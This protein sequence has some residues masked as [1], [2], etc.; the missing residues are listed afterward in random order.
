MGGLI[1]IFLR[2]MSADAAT[3][4]F[5]VLV[6]AVFLFACHQARKG[7]AQAFV[8]NAPALMTSLGILG[9]FVGIVIGLLSFDVSTIDTSISTLLEGMKTAFIT[10]LV[11]MTFSIAFKLLD[12]WKFSV[13]RDAAHAPQ[14]VTPAHILGALEKQTQAIG[15]LAT[16]LSGNEE[17]S[18]VGQM[19]LFRSDVSD[20]TRQAALAREKFEQKLLVDL[21]GVSTLKDFHAQQL[22][23][24]GGLH[25]LITQTANRQDE[26]RQVL[27]DQLLATTSE[28]STKLD[29]AS[30]RRQNQ[31]GEL[32]ASLQ[33]G[34][35][36]IT[37]IADRQDEARKQFE[38]QL[39][40]E[41][42]E[43][44][45]LMSRS[46]TEAVIEALRQV[47]VEF[48]TNLTE[49]FGENFKAL[50]ASVQKL[51]EWQDR[52]A[53]QV[54]QMGQQFQRSVD[55]VDTTR[56]ALVKIG[57]ECS[58]IPASMDELRAVIVIN[59][60]QIQELARH[61]E[62]FVQMRDKAVEA[63]PQ[64]RE[65]IGFV[66]EQL[67]AAAVDM[68]EVLAEKSEL[69][70]S[71]VN[72][73]NRAV[74]EMANEVS[75]STDKLREEF[76]G[77]VNELTSAA[78]EMVRSLEVAANEVH[79]QVRQS[80]EGMVDAIQRDT[81]RMLSG[82]EKQV[83]EAVGKTGEAVNTQLSAIDQGLAQELERVFNRFGTS[84]ARISDA[85]TR[86]YENVVKR[87]AEMARKVS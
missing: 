83:A 27:K 37:E 21:E 39:F 30:E 67:G 74:I 13:A 26:A 64:I 33:V 85:Y 60:H 71:H 4:V 12:D 50:D 53:G 15:G 66:T 86:D 76:T 58:R 49:Q 51:V 44:A 24:M 70:A 7:K 20:Q 78:R 43:F 23:L 41:M 73:T 56:E 29:Q 87:I 81:G 75:N 2:G 19:K 72:S 1:E 35:E 31:H 79:E 82:V 45:D 36:L 40:A 57:E 84:L 38:I 65:Q 5:C 62:A 17:G 22:S 54:D 8:R 18:I 77:S 11:G 80:T 68:S 3:E 59:Q 9:T 61:L 69:F 6:V 16:L 42:K 32:L 10:S 55:G 52:Y 28:V 34:R 46:A 14:A 48:N 47:I 63:V 25:D